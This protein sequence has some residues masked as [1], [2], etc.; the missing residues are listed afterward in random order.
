VWCVDFHHEGVFIGVNGTPTNLVRSVWCQ[1]VAW[2]PS[3]MVDRSGGVASTDSGF[4]S[5]CRFVAT[6]AWAEPPQTLAGPWAQSA[7][8]LAH[9]VHISNTPHGDD[10]FDIGQIHF[11][12]P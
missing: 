11:V 9:L 3:H 8:G 10:D 4:S 2:Q 6:K 1:V 7:W 12:I 5:L